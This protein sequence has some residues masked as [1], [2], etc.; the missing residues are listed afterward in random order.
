MGLLFKYAH[1]QE[2]DVCHK[3]QSVKLSSEDEFIF[4]ICSI[5]KNM[6]CPA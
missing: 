3:L 6:V 2:S 4:V 5:H 1:K